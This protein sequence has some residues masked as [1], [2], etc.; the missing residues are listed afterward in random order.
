MNEYVEYE[1]ISNCSGGV[2]FSVQQKVF[3]IQYG[4]KYRQ[5]F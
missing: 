1:Y 3:S 2:I 4:S 5:M